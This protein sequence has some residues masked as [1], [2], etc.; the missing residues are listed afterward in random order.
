MGKSII[1]PC[2]DSFFMIERCLYFIEEGE[3]KQPEES[4]LGKERERE[5]TLAGRCK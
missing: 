1:Y 3:K 5:N 2:L 4:K